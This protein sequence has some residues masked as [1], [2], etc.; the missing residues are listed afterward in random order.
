[1][2][3]VSPV[4]SQG[5]TSVSAYFPADSWYDFYNGN[6]LG[7]SLYGQWITVD[8]PIDKIPI[9]IRGGMYTRVAFL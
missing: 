5:A 8:A 1:M 9:H 2:I 3:K 4:V 7:S 6:S